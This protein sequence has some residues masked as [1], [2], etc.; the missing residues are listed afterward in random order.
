MN[1][2]L[3][4]LQVRRVIFH[5]VPKR[6]SH[7]PDAGGP[8]LSEV[9]SPIT[10]G[11]RAYLRDRIVSS[12]GSSRS[13][14]IQFDP[15]STSPVPRHIQ[16]LANDITVDLVNISQEIARH[17]YGIQTGINPPGLL[18]VIDCGLDSGNAISVLKIERE[19]GVRLDQQTVGGKKTYNIQ[20]LHDLILT[21][22]TRLFKI[23]LFVQVGDDIQAAACDFQRGYTVGRELADFF[24]RKFLGCLLAEDPEVQTKRFYEIAMEFFNAQLKGKPLQLAKVYGHLTSE[25][26]SEQPRIN[27][28]KFAE[29][30]L[31]AA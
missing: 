9:E 16:L 13:F 22:N 1:I 15:S 12:I 24:L 8:V 17:L 28:K 25:L 27:P 4:L 26:S 2:D 21:E 5:D 7:A 20:H 11:M 29:N 10:P 18:A 31:P 19:E 23:A 30:Y 14:E 6:R 3:G